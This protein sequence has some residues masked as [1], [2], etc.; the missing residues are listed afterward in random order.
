MRFMQQPPAAPPQNLLE[1]HQ[2]HHYRHHLLETKYYVFILFSNCLLHQTIM[3]KL[4]HSCEV[5][6]ITSLNDPSL[7]QSKII[8]SS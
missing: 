7:P 5:L 8:I 2:R 3:K 1:H 4:S 6:Q